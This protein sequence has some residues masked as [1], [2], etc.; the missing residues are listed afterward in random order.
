MTS[1][2]FL[3]QFP[4]EILHI[5]FNYISVF[6]LYY[7]LYNVSDYINT[8]LLNYP[9]SLINLKS[10][11]QYHVDFICH[12]IKPD[13]I[14]SLTL[15]DNIDNNGQSELFFSHFHIE[16][17]IQ[18]QSLTLINIENNL[19]KFLLPNLNKLKY[20]RS[21]SFDTTDYYRMINK[22]YRLQF[23]QLKS[24]LLNTCTNLL[25]QLNQLILFDIQEMTLKSLSHLHRLKISECSTTELQKICSEMSQLKSFDVCLQGDPIYIQVLSS[26]SKLTRLI[27]KIDVFKNKFIS[28]DFIEQ[29]LPNLFQLKHFEF[30]TDNG[31]HFDDGK[32]W[33]K[34]TKSFITF[35]FKFKIKY[36]F[37]GLDS[38]RTSF[39][40]EE[41][42]WCV[43]YHN[44]DLY[45]IPRFAPVKCYISNL[46]FINS[47]TP[48]Y[49]IFYERITKLIVST[50]FFNEN[51][52]FPNV[53]TLK[54]NCLVSIE[55][56]SNII[57]LNKV[58]H[59][60]LSSESSISMFLL[61]LSVMPHL[62]ELT[63]RGYLVPILIKELQDNIIKQIRILNLHFCYFEKESI[64]KILCYH[65][66]YIQYLNISL[67]NSIKDIIFF[68]QQLKYLLNASFGMNSLFK[69]DKDKNCQELQM[70]IDKKYTCQ[71]V[72]ITNQNA[73]SFVHIWDNE[74]QTLS[75][76]LATLL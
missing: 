67:I 27:L 4:V 39:W 50:E 59:L 69:K 47:N 31:D 36:L 55:R 56:L 16:Q 24:I 71:I 63:I 22:D 53:K 23:T 28:M 14:I 51:H 12:Y 30:Q 33:E 1:Y 62:N 29:F 38:F 40:L 72:H 43:I 25:S 7:N 18:L 26:L 11:V 21:F 35:N 20:L 68:I 54:M 37:K 70:A 61:A 74:Y 10:S 60:I 76:F 32:R 8:V 58:K 5:V 17:F 48:N 19:L 52:Y 57:N 73:L 45:T 49:T 65:F 2:C 15:F 42:H 75:S 66:P 3:D 64:T 34:L 46:L 44:E 13:Q 41:K 6:E 9:I